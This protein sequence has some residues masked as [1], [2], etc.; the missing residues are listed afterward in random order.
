MIDDEVVNG[1]GHCGRTLACLA[2]VETA[3]R[4]AHSMS[5]VMPRLAWALQGPMVKMAWPGAATVQRT[6]IGCKSARGSKL[7]C[8][9]SC[10]QRSPPTLP[11]EATLDRHVK[12]RGLSD[13]SCNDFF[14]FSRADG[15]PQRQGLSRNTSDCMRYT[16][17]QV[18]GQRWRTL[19]L[20]FHGTGVVGQVSWDRV[21]AIPPSPMVIAAFFSYPDP[22]FIL[23]D[24]SQQVSRGKS[25]QAVDEFT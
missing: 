11:C 9:R 2:V 12:R 6:R 23:R 25:A 20:I 17:A 18:A 8:K 13:Q 10:G 1:N 4:I 22:V 16:Q 19:S 5:M 15:D 21:V 3:H 24:L 7:P 14:Q